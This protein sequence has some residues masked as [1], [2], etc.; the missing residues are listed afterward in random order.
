VAFRVD[1]LKRYSVNK[2]CRHLASLSVAC[3]SQ[4]HIRTIQA[5][6]DK[7]DKMEREIVQKMIQDGKENKTL[8]GQLLEAVIGMVW[9]DLVLVWSRPP[10][11]GL[12]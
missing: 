8:I 11:L 3:T 10:S 12:V 1:R 6:R 9:S 7:L 4:C 2:V 5:K